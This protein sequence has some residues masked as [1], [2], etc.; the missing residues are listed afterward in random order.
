[1][2]SA[3]TIGIAVT[4][5]G[6][7]SSH[8]SKSVKSFRPVPVSVMICMGQLLGIWLWP[9]LGECRNNSLGVGLKG[10]NPTIMPKKNT[11][12]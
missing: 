9:L 6:L 7:R 10:R 11:P 4:T 12:R 3:C 1:M 8:K 2:G 5:A